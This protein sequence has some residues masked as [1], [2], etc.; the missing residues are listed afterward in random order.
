MTERKKT[1]FSH[2]FLHGIADCIKS[3]VFCSV[4]VSTLLW[5]KRDETGRRTLSG[6][7]KE[8]YHRTKS[9]RQGEIRKTIG[10]AQSKQ[11]KNAGGRVKRRHRESKMQ[12][13][14]R[15]KG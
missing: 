4:S 7:L 5:D 3:P 9:D 2:F 15:K 1:Q 11:L 6:A 14:D 12:M 13:I 8:T 10:G